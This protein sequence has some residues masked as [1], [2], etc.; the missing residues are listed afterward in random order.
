M[1]TK[2]SNNV[3][4]TNPCWWLQLWPSSL[5]MPIVWFLNLFGIKILDLELTESTISQNQWNFVK[6]TYGGKHHFLWKI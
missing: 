2:E 1:A 3:S 4:L 6:D 5:N